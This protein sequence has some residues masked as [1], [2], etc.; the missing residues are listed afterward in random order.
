LLRW[1][2]K[3]KSERKE[4]VEGDEGGGSFLVPVFSPTSCD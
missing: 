1:G 3:I 4:D 2:S